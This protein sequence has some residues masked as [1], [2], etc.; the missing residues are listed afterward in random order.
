[1]RPAAAHALARRGNP[2][3][4]LHGDGR[5]AMASGMAGPSPRS[6][7]V[8]D[9]I[10]AGLVRVS[11]ESPGIRR[12]RAGAGFAYV[13]PGGRP[14]RDAKTLGR[15]R[16]LAIPPAW[17]DVWICPRADGHVQAVGRDAK[18]RK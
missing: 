15:I 4:R 6:A 9:A 12:R 2:A 5:S 11:D 1:M 3:T 18:G 7:D 14:V 16:A 17:T 8:Q 13:G 10:D